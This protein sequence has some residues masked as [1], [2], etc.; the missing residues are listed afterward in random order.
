MTA[1]VTEHERLWP[2]GGAPGE[3]R[4][5]R[6]RYD[7]EAAGADL[8][9]VIESLV[10]APLTV[11][12]DVVI[13]MRGDGTELEAELGDFWFHTD[14]TFLP[15]PPRWMA[16][17]VQEADSGG[18]LDLLPAECVDPVPLAT[19]VGYR[20]SG[21]VL[22]APVLEPLPGLTP[23]RVRYRQDRMTAAGGPD[24]TGIGGP[25]ALEEVH[26]AVLA[27]AEQATVPAGELRAGDCLLLDNWTVLHR[28]GDF[29]GRRVIR[30]LWLDPRDGA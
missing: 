10:G 24:T 27:A 5:M 19:P 9:A 22:T 11:L 3:A 8:P 16:I 28:R 25:D 2:P 21:G 18:A 14:A 20:A 26:D 15:S 23:G 13:G 1:T 4:A 7:P 29:T 6:F 30:R 12:R 17:L